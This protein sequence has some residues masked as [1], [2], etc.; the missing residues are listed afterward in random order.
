LQTN[1]P[2]APVY[3]IA[4]QEHFNDLV[5]ATYGRGFWILD[6][7]TPLQQLTAEVLGADAHLFPPRA[8]YRLRDI[9]GESSSFNDPTV[10]QNP[11]YGASINYYLK[12]APSGDVT[13]SILD[14]GNQVLRTLNAPKAAGLNRVYW[15][16]RDEPTTEVR[17]RTSPLYAPDIQ[18]GSDG[19]RAAQAA[20]R[21]SILMPPGTYTVRLNVGGRQLSQK[22]EIR[23]DPNSGGTEAD[24][25]EQ[26]K[27]LTELKRDISAAAAM[28]NDIELVRAQIQGLGRV[29]QNAE[30]MKPAGE[31]EQRLIEIEQ[32]LLE[33]RV[34]GRGQDGVRFG[35]RL[36]GKLG[37]LAN[38]LGSGDF[39]PTN[40]QLEV[41][42]V[43]QEQLRKHQTSLEALL[44]RDLKAFNE[45]MR[46]RGVS[47]I[48]V[49]RPAS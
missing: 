25:K 37:Y 48:I 41:Q 6:D 35:A 39:R 22:L 10:G 17:M 16:L 12:A 32:N 19:T 33:L 42:K 29:L 14:G 18:V 5:I 47:N 49:R 28:A 24:I 2:R 13:I 30:I 1:M 15:D 4:R 34:T 8:T 23:K 43:L 27:M 11:P 26:M 45:L 36:L 44:E 40:Q 46:G 7:L 3:W 31:L 38:G 21:L 9:T 20:G